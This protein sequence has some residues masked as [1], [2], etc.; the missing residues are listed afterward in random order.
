MR[1]SLPQEWT[2][3]GPEPDSEP[4]S[5]ESL[6]VLR[7]LLDVLACRHR[8]QGEIRNPDDQPRT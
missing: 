2:D 4:V 7:A 3:R 5:A 1:V 6:A 8:D